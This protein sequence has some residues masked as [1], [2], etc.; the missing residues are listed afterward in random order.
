MRRK[1]ARELH[2][3]LARHIGLSSLFQIRKARKSERERALPYSLKDMDVLGAFH[4]SRID[5]AYW[6]VFA[7]VQP[8]TNYNNYY[9]VVG[10]VNPKRSLAEMHSCN[11]TELLWTYDPRL[12][13]ERNDERKQRFIQMHGSKEVK[14]SLPAGNISVDDFLSDVFCVLDIRVAADD[15]DMDISG[16]ESVTFPEGRRIE[17]MHK[18][19]ERSSHVVRKAKREHAKRHGGKLPCEVCEFNFSERYGHRG[20]DYIEAHHRVPLGDL[21][22]QQCAETSISD[23]AMVCANCHRMLHKRPWLTVKKLR[24]QLLPK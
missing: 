14:I 12:Q 7:N 16:R 11:E 21:D 22:E 5:A 6:L 19:R 13:D 24:K 10:Q 15:L 3:S 8:R 20:S 23:L 4:I 9:L 17:R 2:R 1:L 18:F